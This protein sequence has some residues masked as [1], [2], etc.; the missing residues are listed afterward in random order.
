MTS[1]S[2]LPPRMPASWKDYNRSNSQE[3][4]SYQDSNQFKIVSDLE[5]IIDVKMNVVRELD[6]AL[7][8]NR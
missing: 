7:N 3:L 4:F 6:L 2:N 5:R 1:Q 8:E